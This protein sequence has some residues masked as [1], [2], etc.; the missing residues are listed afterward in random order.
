MA[1]FEPDHYETAARVAVDVLKQ[2]QAT[3]DL[4][5]RK[6]FD[7]DDI[8]PILNINVPDCA[9]E[10]LKGTKVTRLGTRHAAPPATK[11]TGDDSN[12]RYWLGPAGEVNDD[13]D[14]TDFHAVSTGYVSITPLITDQTFYQQLNNLEKLLE[15]ARPGS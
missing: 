3:T 13:S 2:L 12:N 7:G 5:E 8:R 1:S 9:Y 15:P 14:E 4:D 6:V 10:E 11:E